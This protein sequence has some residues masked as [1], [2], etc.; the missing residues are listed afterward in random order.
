LPQ[1]KRNI[2]K[3]DKT[4][5][6]DKN[7]TSRP[8]YVIAQD[9][10]SNWPKVN[11]AARPYLDAMATL[12]SIDQKY[13]YDTGKSIVLYFLANAGTWRGDA[14]RTIKKELKTI[15]GIK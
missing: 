9:I 4:K 2:T 6:G 15:A 13:Y 11:Y 1:F 3:S 12:E 5:T 14:A 8:L 7:M 10:K